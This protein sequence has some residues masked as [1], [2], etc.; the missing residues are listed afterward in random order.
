MAN[1][2]RTLVGS[3]SSGQTL[4]GS[5]KGGSGTTD[6]SRLINRA[7]EDQHPIEAIA[8]L[9]D[10]LDSKLNSTTA[11]PL[12]DEA[13]KGKAKGLYFDA[14]KELARKSYWYLTAEID[15]KT[16]LGTKNSIISGPYDLGM[17][18]GSGGGGGGGVTTVSV[19]Q[20][21][22]PTVAPVGNSSVPT[23]IKI[24][25][26]SV[27][28]EDRTPTGEGTVYLIINGKQVETRAKQAQGPV[29]F[30]I[31]SYLI[32]GDNIVQV[33]VL[34]MYGTTG[35]TVGMI[36]GVSLELKSTF[37]QDIAFYGKIDFTYTPVG[38]VEKK[39]YFIIDGDIE[40]AKYEIIKSSNE[41]QTYTIYGLTHGSHTL[42]VYFEATIGGQIIPSNE[43]FYD[44]LFVEEKNPT[45]IIASEF[46]TFTQ[47]Q[48]ISFNV[49]YR[50][51]IDGRSMAMITLK[52]NGQT[53]RT[54]EV[55][56]NGTH[57]WAYRSDEPTIRV[58]AT[59]EITRLK[60]P[61]VLEIFCEDVFKS[62]T[63]DVVESK[64]TVTPVLNNLELALSANGRSNDELESVRNIW[65]YTTTP[66]AGS[67]EEP[68]TYNC[69][70][71]N[72]NWSSDGWVIDKVDEE[73][74]PLPGSSTV[75]RVGGAARVEIPL[76]VFAQNFTTSGKTIE[77]EIAT[78]GIRDY[79]TPIISCLDQEKSPFYTAEPLYEKE[80]ERS[81]G[82]E[83][84]Y[85]Y[86]TLAEAITVPGKYL[87]VFNGTSWTLESKDAN[88]QSVYTVVNLKDYG[89]TLTD[90]LINAEGKDLGTVIQGDRILITFSMEAR[91]FEIT[92]QV[93]SI[94]SQQSFLST[95]YKEDEHVRVSFVVEPTNADT[96]KIIWMYINGVASGAMQYPNGDTFEQKQ[97]SYITIGSSEATV[98]I[99]NIRVYN[100]ALTNRQIVNNWIAD[101]ADA[102]LKASR[103]NHNQV[104]NE[105]DQ[106][107][108][109]SLL[110]G[111]PDLPYIIWDIDPLPQAKEDVRPGNARYV[112]PTDSTRNFTAIDA[113]YKVQGTSSAVYPT[114]NIRL[115]A[116]KGKG[117]PN[118]EWYDDDGNDLLIKNG[119]KGFPITY[120][121]G[122]GVDYFTFKVDY[123]S[124][125]GANNVELVKLYN[126]ASIKYGLLTPPQIKDSRVRVGIDGFPIAAFHQNAVGDISFCTKA[127]FNNDKSNPD[128]YGFA[129][130]DES[131]ETTNNSAAEA[132]YQKPVTAENFAKG[133]EIRYPDE[134]DWN[135][136]LSKLSQMTAWVA[137]T[138]T[139]E[140][141]VTKAELPESKTYDIKMSVIAASDLADGAENKY[142]VYNKEPIK[143]E[144]GNTL[145]DAAGNDVL[146]TVS[147]TF[148]HDTKSYRLS[149]FKNELEDF[150]NVDSC[151]FYYLFTELFLMID[152]RAKNAFPTYYKSRQ[153]GDG[154]DRWFW[155]PYDMDTAIG[156][157]NKGKLTFDYSL[158]D[159]DKLD[160]ADVYNGQSS[161]MWCNVRDAFRTELVEMY[162]TLRN[163]GLIS[164]DEVER[165]FEEHQ[166]K[167]PEVILNLDSHNKYIVPLKKGDNYLEMLQGT[168]AQQRKWWLYNRF[169]YIDSK[170]NAGD[171]KADFLQFRAYVDIGKEKPDLE[172]TPYANIYATASFG[173][174]NEFTVSKRVKQ[175]G[176]TV[177]LKNP[178]GLADD[179]N[180]QETYIYSASQLQSI[181]DISGFH[182]DTVKIGN[183]IRLQDLKV[184]DRDPN[185]K[186]PYLKELTV[187]ANTLLKSIDAR[188]CVNLGTGATVAPDLRGCTNIEEIYFTGTKIK[189]IELPDGGTIKT[190]HLPGTL[191]ALTIK[192]HP[193]LTDLKIE[194]TNTTITKGSTVEGGYSFTGLVVK[195]G[196]WDETNA[197]ADLYLADSLVEGA[198]QIRVN[199]SSKESLYD[200]VVEGE[201]KITITCTF[202]DARYDLID[203][204]TVQLAEYAT[205][206]ISNA[207]LS[208]ATP[209]VTAVLT[210]IAN[211]IEAPT[212][213]NFQE[214]LIDTLWLEGIP[215]SA[216]K[217][218]EFI[219]NMKAD[220]QV[221]LMG[222]NETYGSWEEIK[223]FYDYLDRHRGIDKTG[224]GRIPE[225]PQVTGM[226][227]IDEIS[228]K[229]YTEL[230]ARYPE[231]VINAKKIISTV[232]FYN[233]GRYENGQYLG[234][235]CYDSFNIELNTH[236]DNANKLVIE[237]K[238]VAAPAILPTKEPTQAHY[239]TFNRWL[240]QPKIYT[241]ET[242][243]THP[244]YIDEEKIPTWTPD[245]IITSDIR[246]DAKYDNH[247]QDYRVTFDTDSKNIFVDEDHQDLVV[248]YGSLI[249]APTTTEVEGVT[250][251]GWFLED[252]PMW[253]FE[254]MP[255]LDNIVL[256]AKWI[257]HNE[258]T[259][260]LSRQNYNTFSYTATDNLGIVGWAVV[261]DSEDAPTVWNPTPTNESVPALTGTYSIESAG[262]YHF[263]ILDAGGNTKK[264][265]I[266]AYPITFTMA[267]KDPLNAQVA[268]KSFTYYFTEQGQTFSSD[269]AL[270]NTKLDLT[271]V[272]DSHYK[273]L[274]INNDVIDTLSL[275]VTQPI[276]VSL[277][278]VPKNYVVT[279]ELSGKGNQDKAPTQVI[280]YLHTAKMPVEQYDSNEN[281][282]I[283]QWYTDQSYAEEYLW[284]FEKMPVRGPLTLYANWEEVTEPTKI[285]LSLPA[286]QNVLVHFNYSQYG[287]DPVRID[288]GDGSELSLSDDYL[289]VITIDHIYKKEYGEKDYI[290]SIYK[291]TS[292]RS[293][294]SLGGGNT[295]HAVIMPAEYITDVKFSW[296]IIGAPSGRVDARENTIKDGAFANT[297]LSH[298]NF[299]PY[300]E[301]ISASCFAGCQLLT[302]LNIPENITDV[303]SQAFN[304]CNGLTTLTV[305]AHIKSLG[306]GAFQNCASL[307]TVTLNVD[308]ASCDVGSDLFRNC[309]K[310][311]TVNFNPKFTCIASHMFSGCSGLEELD[312]PDTI[313]EIQYFAFMDCASL[314]KITTNASYIGYSAFINCPQLSSVVLKN[315]RLNLDLAPEVTP[316]DYIFDKCPKL[317]SAGPIGETMQDGSIPDIQFAWDKEI[318][319]YAFRRGYYS[320]ASTGFMSTTKTSLNE[321]KLPVGLEVIGPHAFGYGYFKEIILP[322]TLTTIGELAF[323]GC[324]LT[325]IEIP[326]TVTS[327][328][329]K[330][331]TNCY[332]TRAIINAKSSNP[333]V[334]VA[335]NAWFLGCPSNLQLVIPAD[336]NI[337]R[338][339]VFDAYGEYWH[340]R[341]DTTGATFDWM[342]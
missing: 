277:S 261:K 308:S 111:A 222:I 209:N 331:F 173:N 123:A 238:T 207:V 188:N 17:G 140:N 20:V 16:G 167:W 328:G 86:S 65:T 71:T 56:T 263:W 317:N 292:N 24:T 109:A 63:V 19:K 137:S 160:G 318:P 183:A 37:N 291:P 154:G 311:K 73:G 68:R 185:Y 94:R 245:Y 332:L 339:N 336:V 21:E 208:T 82:Y 259:I 138:N 6:H 2:K 232:K 145:K 338:Q 293:T 98:D 322:E 295:D 151:L 230:R 235:D 190:L 313:T 149:K 266:T 127:N 213:Q 179:E 51:F 166:N 135:G 243:W 157:D 76:E 249:T 90:A 330:A 128:V 316:G 161:V 159:E 205:R 95:Q 70:F 42:K 50:V 13:L 303:R 38:N 210:D 302:E 57:I 254:T 262:V 53:V 296:D 211:R 226:I 203:E 129:A 307:H 60:E 171:A 298:I 106:V 281:A 233:K 80:E 198:P 87:F 315:S 152:S 319:K 131:W 196:R 305:P 120:P 110:I 201:T 178:F 258:P 29:E 168:K 172:I 251:I 5:V 34:D 25:W 335:S 176:E 289:N 122:M 89:I 45:P 236:L 85:V 156:I 96:N 40:N 212:L 312:L 300:M 105:H 256:K 280:T 224:S 88:N 248:K 216:I 41:L 14:L 324:L 114:K 46:N 58:S 276:E 49:P 107:V 113:E 323:D 43:L 199:T 158:E 27:I 35:V 244:V 180:D 22:W 132:K 142:F 325:T 214:S 260:S 342:S 175:R 44:V 28:G 32:S 195:K 288:W 310:L 304:G 193:L 285:T 246:I 147:V 155:I 197:N 116:K 83:V 239:Y 218:K 181:G 36:S 78:H 165:R 170:Y 283:N 333:T 81:K 112:D 62:F 234:G 290:V 93:A 321:V 117:G 7:N 139:D 294:Y 272:L 33:K 187:G 163:Q 314:Q 299:T 75:L 3:I 15:P 257:D 162:L 306:S 143:D 72:F 91:G 61:L 97:K 130:G 242:G 326:V 119:G 104:L 229:D 220:T 101:T 221:S 59:G 23:K 241:L 247:L 141:V 12:I 11:L 284:D 31:S 134:D 327:I 215:S 255:V 121:G 118:L 100:S 99:Y 84:S 223:E 320:T 265:F 48:Y 194:S 274:K 146:Q 200:L 191:T 287:G 297:R 301:S 219:K 4:T 184:G 66:P 144:D 329:A 206:L 108:P 252:G 1:G 26:A 282:I 126:D 10:E 18:G 52:A 253:N 271:V 267:I 270:S 204:T 153:E 192:N 9:R 228:Y 269:F 54:S 77:L 231:V 69:N 74:V 186:N 103:F 148:S 169:K 125:E 177:V 264:D 341:D 55:T 334:D 64:I 182:P 337:S 133:F 237:G 340:Y 164:Y 102:A 92:P 30:D 217:A 240:A 136:D 202:I 309:E 225:K 268:D 286:A 115:R 273:D 227:N 279:F 250:L 174:G 8:G 67:N 189:G 150:F 275:D 47:E 278:C 124:S 39:V 79:E